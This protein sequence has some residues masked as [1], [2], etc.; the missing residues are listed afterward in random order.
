MEAPKDKEDDDSDINEG[1]STSKKSKGK[2]RKAQAENDSKR[3]N[4]RP[5]AKDDEP[6][7]TDEEENATP[8]CREELLEQIKDLNSERRMRLLLKIL[9]FGEI[10]FFRKY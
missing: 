6:A 3:A 5:V 4:R 7:G 8:L 10:L 9:I 1:A 2:S